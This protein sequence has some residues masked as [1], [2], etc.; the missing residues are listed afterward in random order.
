VETKTKRKTTK[1]PNQT[2]TARPVIGW[3]ENIRRNGDA[4]DALMVR[5]LIIVA[6][7]AAIVTWGVA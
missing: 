4:F 5:A 7:L 2:D 1:M 3:A 6:V